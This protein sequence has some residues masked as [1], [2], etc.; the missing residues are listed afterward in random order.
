MDKVLRLL[1]EPIATPEGDPN[2]WLTRCGLM[3]QHM[4]DA[5]LELQLQCQAARA[6]LAMGQSD[7][8][9]RRLTLPTHQLNPQDFLPED[10][11]A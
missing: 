2:P 10:S 11:H 5:A 7:A 1:M 3:R 6:E 8:V 9:L 4:L